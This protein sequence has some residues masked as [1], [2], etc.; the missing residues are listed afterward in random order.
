MTTPHERS[1][2][3]WALRWVAPRAAVVAPAALVVGV[4]SSSSC[5]TQ[6]ETTCGQE[7][8][9]LAPLRGKLTGDVIVT[10]D[11]GNPI[12][13]EAGTV[14]PVCETPDG[15]CP[16]GGGGVIKRGP[17]A[18]STVAVEL[19]GLYSDN[20]D[21]SRGHPN[22][23][24][25]T[26]TREDGTFELMAPKG[27]VGLH[28]FRNGWFYGRIEVPDAPE[29]VVDDPRF[30]EMAALRSKGPTLGNFRVTPT[31]AKPGEILSF[32]VNTTRA[33]KD[34]MS[35]ELV[36]YELTTTAARA[37]APPSRGSP[38]REVGAARAGWPDG[39]WTATMPAPS[40]PGLYTFYAHSTSEHCV[41]SNRVSL[42][43][44]VR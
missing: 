3:G 1:S 30:T 29:R 4:A 22:Y 9:E 20:P 2:F 44:T 26:V 32:S 40:Q 5:Y 36:V 42:Q 39:T 27:K 38:L 31:E 24:Y 21:P 43:V 15:V 13:D 35:E 12:L 16:P 8:A 28:T 18:G 7:S 34:P 25:A 41:S 19:C 33:G 6:G 37:F 14:I 10:D 17:Q 11:A 23:R